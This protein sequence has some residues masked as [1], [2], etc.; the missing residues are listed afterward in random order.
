MPDLTSTIVIRPDVVHRT[1]GEEALL[2]NLESGMYYGLNAVGTRAWA[3][4]QSENV[5]EACRA[6]AAEFDAPV[7][8]IRQDVLSLVTE[9]IDKGLVDLAG[10]DRA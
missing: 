4:L 7:E 3:L 8:Q 5:G 10:D 2:L 6:L 9:L 1:L